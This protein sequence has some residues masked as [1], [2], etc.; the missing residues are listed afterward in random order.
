MNDNVNKTFPSAD[1]KSKIIHQHKQQS[2]NNELRKAAKDLIMMMMMMMMMMNC[3]CGMD[4]PRKM[5]FQPGYCQRYSPF[6]SPI[7]SKQD[8]N[9]HRN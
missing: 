6:E 5:Y 1:A 9:L 7:C 4:D 3:F 2:T 8:L